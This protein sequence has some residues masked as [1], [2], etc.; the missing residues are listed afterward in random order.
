[1]PH[2]ARGACAGNIDEMQVFRIEA[3]SQPC[4]EGPL[5]AAPS[6]V[7]GSNAETGRTNV[8]TDFS[9][10]PSESE[11]KEDL[12]QIWKALSG[13]SQSL[14]ADERARKASRQSFCDIPFGKDSPICGELSLW[15]RP[16]RRPPVLMCAE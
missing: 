1:M 8:L 12:K 10:W 16:V 3:D 13:T 14:L 11:V 9:G 7:T 2:P 15:D 4:G 5:A 6:P